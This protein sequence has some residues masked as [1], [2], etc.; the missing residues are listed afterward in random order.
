MLNSSFY[1]PHSSL[2]IYVAKM[3][4]IKLILHREIKL[5][6]T[7]LHSKQPPNLLFSKNVAK[8]IAEL[9]SFIQSLQC[10]HS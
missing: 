6:M 1:H 4:P 3:I 9:L 10:F 2:Q 8:C 5:Q 7:M